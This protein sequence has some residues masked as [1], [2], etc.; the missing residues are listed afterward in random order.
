MTNVRILRIVAATAVL[1]QVLL[2]GCAGV[3]PAPPEK[4]PERIPGAVE[5]FRGLAERYEREGD[6]RQALIRWEVV[7]SLRHEDPEAGRK[8]AE[9]REKIADGSQKYFDRGVEDYRHDKTDEARKNFLHSLSLD[10]GNKAA[11]N[12]LKE[13]L[14]GDELTP[15]KVKKGDTLK[16]IALKSYGDADKAFAIAYFNQMTVNSRLSAGD[17]VMVPILE[18]DILERRGAAPPP[19]EEIR[20][21]TEPKATVAKMTET[22]GGAIVEATLFYKSREYLRSIAIARKILDNDPSRK[23]ARDLLSASCYQRGKAL[24]RQEKYQ[25]AVE[26]F[27]C[28]DPEYKDVKNLAALSRRRLADY[29]YIRGVELFVNEKIEAAIAQWKL[30]L[31]ADPNHPKA[32]GDI[33]NARALL[34]KMKEIK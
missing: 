16:S 24:F 15:Y 33:E 34:Q 4:A 25:G 9:L 27:D 31:D 17:T 19:D 32:A 21:I 14:S 30:A 29:Y 6:L 10:P 12:Y 2:F 8:I 28:A 1:S 5:R 7:A 23:D 20:T 22:R 11:L 18:P 13:K 26:M 3:K